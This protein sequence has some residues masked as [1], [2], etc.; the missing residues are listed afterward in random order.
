MGPTLILSYYENDCFLSDWHIDLWIPWLISIVMCYSKTN[1][2]DIYFSSQH[3]NRP[4]QMQM[5]LRIHCLA[6]IQ[7]KIKMDTV[8]CQLEILLHRQMHRI[9]VHLWHHNSSNHRIKCHRLV[10]HHKL[11]RSKLNCRTL[12]NSSSNSHN[13]PSNR[14]R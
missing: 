6:S 13:L 10:S 5:L 9:R 8:T 12:N 2:I 3:R 7:I 14:K 4:N 1:R 11:K